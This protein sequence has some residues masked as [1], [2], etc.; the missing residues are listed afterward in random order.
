MKIGT[1]FRAT[2]GYCSM[3]AGVIYYFIRFDSK[4]NKALFCWF[5]EGKSGWRVYLTYLSSD[6]LDTALLSTPALIAPL[7][8][9][10]TLPPWLIS[11]D[12]TNFDEIEKY[13]ASS[14]QTYRDQVTMRYLHIAPLISILDTV[15]M[16]KN[17]M[18]L[19]AAHARQCSPPQNA[20]RIQLWFFAY[21]AHGK[22]IWALKK[23]TH[24]AG[25]WHRDSDAHKDTKF[26]RP[27]LHQGS[28]YGY[29]TH[30]MKDQ[31]LTCYL[32]R[33]G[34]GKRMTDIHADSCIQDFGCRTETIK[35]SRFRMYHPH[36]APFP[37]YY[38]FRKVVIEQFG[39][40]TVQISLY[41][42]E[43]VKHSLPHVGAFTERLSNLLESLEVDA[44]RVGERAKS[45]YSE[46]HMSTLCVVR[47]ICAVSGEVVGVGFSVGSETSKAYR[48]M[49][50][51]M[52]IPKSK[53]G[54][55]F[56]LT[57][58]DEQW[59]V[60]CM[61]LSYLTDRGPGSK[62]PAVALQEKFP[63]REMPPSN[64][65][66]GKALVESSQP[67]K[68]HFDGAKRHKVSGLNLIELSRREILRACKDNHTSSI[69]KRLTP[70]MVSHFHQHALPATPHNIW[71]YLSERLRTDAV[72]IPFDV[73]VRAFCDPVTFSIRDDGA[74]LDSRCYRSKEL[75][76]SKLLQRSH[77][78]IKVEVRGYVFPMCVRIVWI[79]NEGQLQELEG[80]LRLRDE[81]DQLTVTFSEL[82][83]EKVMRSEIESL[84]RESIQAAN[85][86][87]RKDFKDA[88][89]KDW[90]SGEM[91][92]GSPKRVSGETAF[93]EQQLKGQT[94]GKKRA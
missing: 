88:T 85:A 75:S 57:I 31:I 62:D 41:G 44:F 39:L 59:P 26:G 18:K 55:L 71:N 58:T 74:W 90:D 65:G 51:S 87:Y 37:S 60:A 92:G 50:F 28:S 12:G 32:R 2:R 47:G 1:Q 14:K 81:Q 42:A 70:N 82:K 77:N 94:K 5:S 8:Q 27:C 38:Q 76:E 67:K 11:M 69:S 61:T 79:E 84:T 6:Q 4:L 23:P 73:A 9:Q 46:N 80:V 25:S 86:E 56:G 93:E 16:S 78:G 53:L 36:N 15:L 72:Q 89:G 83:L 66:Q 24:N 3:Q 33:C 21:I 43:R 10:F 22:N 91:R 13:R 19:L 40:K 34:L 54:Q 20:H 29:P 63:M 68:T 17:P 7:E 64:S 49:L 35:N 48:A 52:A 30:K 45:M